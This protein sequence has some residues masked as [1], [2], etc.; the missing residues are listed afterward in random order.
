MAQM[1]PSLKVNNKARKRSVVFG[2]SLDHHIAAKLYIEQVCTH[3]WNR[4][5]IKEMNYVGG[6]GGL[7]A[8]VNFLCG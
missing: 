4:A 1:T 6:L 2:F 5:N 3:I 8:N 7:R